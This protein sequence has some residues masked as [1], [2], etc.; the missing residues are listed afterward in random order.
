MKKSVIKL[1]TECQDKA[2]ELKGTLTHW[3]VTMSGHVHYF[4]QPK[5][6]DDQGQPLRRLYLEKERLDVKDKDFEEVEVPM[7][8][9]GTIITDKASGFTGMATSFVRHING[10]FHAYIQPKGM[11]RKTNSP[12]EA[13]DFDL[14]SCTG[15]MIEKM[16][17]EDLKKSKEDKPS[18]SGSGFSIEPRMRS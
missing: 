15:K 5:G 2:T 9:L 17:K 6:L 14:R 7:E 3:M 16:S 13:C 18:P 12:I 8:I 10:C 11:N 4:F 1:G